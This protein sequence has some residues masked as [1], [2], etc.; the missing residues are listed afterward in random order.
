MLGIAVAVARAQDDD[1]LLPETPHLI[2]RPHE[3]SDL[4][5]YC[6]LEADADVRR[7]IGG[8]PRARDAAEALFHER[9]LSDPHEQLALWA[10]IYKPEQRWIGYC[11]IY[12]RFLPHGA[13]VV[14]LEGALGFAFARSYWGRGLASEAS[15][16]FVKYGFWVLGL[17][18]IVATV[19]AGN[20]VSLRVL[21]KAGFVEAWFEHGA[22]H[23]YHHLECVR[24]EHIPDEL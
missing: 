23:G 12:P 18:R 4:D 24:P 10:A 2:F 7:W 5:A 20:T 16:A 21:E 19:Q 17:T 6:A 13:G 11:G 3:S 15:R 9:F 8:S 14:Q 1:M 22:L